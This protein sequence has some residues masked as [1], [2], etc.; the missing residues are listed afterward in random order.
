[1]LNLDYG[2]GVEVTETFR[3]A[4]YKH[5]CGYGLNAQ[6]DPKALRFF[7]FVPEGRVFVGGD[8]SQVEARVVA[9]LSHCRELIECF[10]DPTRSVHL[11]NAIAVLGRSVEKDTP[12]YTMAK[13]IVHGSNFREGPKVLSSQ[14]G[15]PIPLCKKLLANYHRKR[16]EIHIWHDDDWN[17]IKTKG[18]LTNFFGD[19]RVFYEAISTFSMLGVMTEQQWKDSIAWIPQSTPPRIVGI[20]LVEIAKL[21]SQG[22]DLW[23][24]HQG[25]DSFLCSV[26]IG[27]EQRFFDK[28]AP[29]F[30]NIKL[31]TPS[32]VFVI[33]VEF[34]VGYNFGDMFKY[35]GKSLD[36]KS[37]QGMV[38]KKLDKLPRNE[39][40]LVGTYGVHL[41]DWRP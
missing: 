21:R 16:P 27:E 3:W 10:D 6:T 9:Y 28:V 12:E 31:N 11:E 22:M 8:L 26:P 4:M 39:Q 35:S 7:K 34:Q 19:T 24:H 41:K 5:P 32:G 1:M 14:C 29:I 18:Q 2:V 23:F 13:S 20:A 25:H 38:D 33:P 17:T 36:Y 37:W 30:A 40:I 15:Q